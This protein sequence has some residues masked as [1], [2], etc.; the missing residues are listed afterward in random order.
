[1]QSLSKHI[2]LYVW[3]FKPLTN[4]VDNF[5]IP[6]TALAQLDYSSDWKPLEI[7]QTHPCKSIFITKKKERKELNVVAA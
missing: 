4:K 6:I 1:M 5:F 7:F 3:F 2:D